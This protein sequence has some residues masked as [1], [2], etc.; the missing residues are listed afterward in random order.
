[1]HLITKDELIRIVIG[2]DPAVTSEPGSD[3]TGIIVCGLGRDSH[4]YVL[5]DLTCKATPDTW[6]RVVANAYKMYEADRIIAEVNNGGDLVASVLHAVD[7][8]LP[9]KTVHAARG[10]ITRADPI[11][12]LYEQGIIHHC[13]DFPD[14]ED[15]LCSWF[16]GL[17]SPDRLDALVWG[18]WE[19]FPENLVL[20][21]VE[22]FE[23]GK[24]AEIMSKPSAEKIVGPTNMAAVMTNDKTE[25]C[26]KCESTII[27]IVSGQK[28]CNQCGFSWDPNA[29]SEPQKK[30]LGGRTILLQK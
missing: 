22:L 16:P 18:F 21:L 3:S 25:R 20:G 26:A 28:H 15:Q 11:S 4:G 30:P 8:N 24:A 7:P 9:V 10:K 12:A 13:G 17:K 29:S 2:V 27:V 5:A 6:A 14:L 19:L 23:S 1:M